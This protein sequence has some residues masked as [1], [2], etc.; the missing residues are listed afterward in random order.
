MTEREAL[1]SL[2]HVV[3]PADERIGALVEEL[4]AEA[5]LDRLKRGRSG[6]RES[7]SY[8]VRLA[9]FDLSTAL[10]QADRIE[11]RIIDR[12]DREWPSQLNDLGNAQP[13][14]I[15][16]LGAANLR[17]AALR[18]V[19]VVGARASTAYGEAVCRDWCP[20]LAAQGFTI[21]SGGAYGIDAA[22]HRATLDAGGMT[23][24]VLACG[25]DVAYPRGHEALISR[26]ASNGLV[27][28]ESPPG[29]EVR[30]H[31]FLTRNRVIAALTRGTLVVEA[32]VRSGTTSTANAAMA[33]NRPVLAVP[34]PVTSPLSGGCHKLVRD[35]DAILASRVEDVFEVVG[36]IG[37]FD[38]PQVAGHPLDDLSSWQARILDVVPRRGATS[39]GALVLAAGLTA[40]DVAGGL[41]ALEIM[42]LVAQD[43]G[44]WRLAGRA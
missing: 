20:S 37:E 7:S 26:I 19:A 1:V 24:C 27:I 31:R 35:T 33:L 41:G 18:S 15:W 17:L 25:V 30:R 9:A 32:A 13:F 16:V 34:G 23:I 2:A 3:E 22:A 40:R 8:Q 12:T 43:E 11:A 38:S 14:A 28:S 29:D 6:L 21:V 36:T 4:G 42:G 10:A 39:F 44:G 5:V